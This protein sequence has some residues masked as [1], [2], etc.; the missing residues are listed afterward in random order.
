MLSRSFGP[1]LSIVLAL[2]SF[3]VGTVLVRSLVPLQ[4]G[5]QLGEKLAHLAADGDQYDALFLGSSR[6][7]RAFD[8][9]RFDAELARAG[10]ALRSYNLG[11]KGVY[12]LEQDFLLHHVL[13]R[14]PARLR[15]IL[16]EAGPIGL[17]LAEH[18]DWARPPQ[19]LTQRAIQWHTP[20]ET[21]R[22]LAAI[23]RLPLP[24]GRRLS[25]AREHLD[26]FARNVTNLG[27]LAHWLFGLPVPGPGR[28]AVD[29]PEAYRALAE[30][31][32]AE[33]RLPVDL[34]ELDLAFYPAQA[35]AAAAAGI[36]L[37]YVTLPGEEGSPEVLALHGLGQLETLFHFND[38]ERHPE[39]FERAQRYD[40]GHLNARGAALFTRRLAAVFL[41]HQ[42]R[43]ADRE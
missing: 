8:A 32:Q 43:T 20:R 41:D 2:L 31:V 35:R 1:G 5:G 9:G 26:L 7:L 25:L 24:L 34:D 23:R 13:A 16:L 14:P 21:R 10:V 39:L 29:A 36:E 37:V 18:S 12:S 17:T 33:N 42:Q 19:P 40:L 4:Q 28:Q 6:V 15:W 3:T 27:V 30:R 22:V 38:P 11:V